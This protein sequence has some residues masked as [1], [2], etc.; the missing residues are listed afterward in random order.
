VLF[1]FK[2]PSLTADCSVVEHLPNTNIILVS[3]S[4]NL[5]QDER[6]QE[7]ERERERLIRK[8]RGRKKGEEE[9]GKKGRM[10]TERPIFFSLAP[11]KVFCAPFLHLHWRKLSSV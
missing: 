10:K 3:I 4:S 8:E 5:K 2:K 11:I 9:G 1:R 7:R 6:K